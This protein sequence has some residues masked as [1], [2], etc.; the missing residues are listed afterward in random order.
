MYPN[1]VYAHGVDK[2]LIRAL[3]SKCAHCGHEAVVTEEFVHVTAI[4]K[5]NKAE[6]VKV[7]L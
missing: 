4:K 3:M 6:A 5:R 1:G 2:S 7:G